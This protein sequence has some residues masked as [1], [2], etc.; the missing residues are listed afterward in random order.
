MNSMALAIDQWL[1]YSV[2]LGRRST[3]LKT[4]PKEILVCF[5]RHLNGLNSYCDTAK[6]AYYNINNRLTI[7]GCLLP[8]DPFS[9]L[10]DSLHLHF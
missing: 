10:T 7:R 3:Q 9:E 5:G 6:Q 8:G 2:F 1:S 4:I